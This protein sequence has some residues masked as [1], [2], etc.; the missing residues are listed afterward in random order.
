MDG[1]VDDHSQ[2]RISHQCGQALP[3]SDVGKLRGIEQLQ[4]MATQQAGESAKQYILLLALA[5]YKDQTGQTQEEN[6][7]TF[8]QYHLPVTAIIEGGIEAEGRPP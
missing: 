8:P 2:K 6:L 1:A 4:E 3:A 5:P 7:P